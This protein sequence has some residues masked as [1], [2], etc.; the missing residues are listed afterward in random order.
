MEVEDI[1][2]FSSGLLLS[3]QGVMND[4]T[5]CNTDSESPK[6]GVESDKTASSSVLGVIFEGNRRKNILFGPIRDFGI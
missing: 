6:R 3:K 4:I 5:C 1:S 2:Q